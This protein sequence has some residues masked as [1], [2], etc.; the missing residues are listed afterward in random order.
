MRRRADVSMCDERHA[1]P[2]PVPSATRAEILAGLAVAWEEYADLFDVCYRAL[3]KP[4]SA[5][6][7]AQSENALLSAY[8]S[9]SHHP[10]EP[11]SED[12]KSPRHPVG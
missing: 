6:S 7:T 11:V 5:A 8:L 12:T 1:T 4:L 10:Q 9:G 3:M 2:P